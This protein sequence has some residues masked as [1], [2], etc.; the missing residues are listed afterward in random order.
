[1]AD[2]SSAEG[3]NT[4]VVKKCSTFCVNWEFAI[5]FTQTYQWTSSSKNS[6]KTYTCVTFNIIPLSYGKREISLCPTSMQ[7]NNPLSTVHNI[8]TVNLQT[9][10]PFPIYT[11]LGHAIPLQKNNT[12][13]GSIHFM[14]TFNF[15]VQK[16]TYSCCKAR[17]PTALL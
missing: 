12:Y 13:W 1:M 2:N 15:H 14:R 9:W 7:E 8:F 6:S 10:S 17:I 16:H 5:L 4:Q 11:N 3:T